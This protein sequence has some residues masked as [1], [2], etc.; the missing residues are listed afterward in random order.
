[1][2]TAKIWLPITRQQPESSKRRTRQVHPVVMIVRLAKVDATIDNAVNG[3]YGVRGFPTI[4][5]FIN[6]TKMDYTG[7]RTTE[8]I[9][10]W[11][12]KRISSATEDISTTE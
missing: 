10:G 1:M 9:I 7:D 11:T 2:A 5:Y 3:E 8:G 12:E 6:G 4:K